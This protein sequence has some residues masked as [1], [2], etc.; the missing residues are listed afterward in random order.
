MNC[1]HSASCRQ[2]RFVSLSAPTPRHSFADAAVREHEVGKT[3]GRGNKFFP[4]LRAHRNRQFPSAAA[5]KILDADIQRRVG[6]RDQGL[7][8]SL[9]KGFHQRD[10]KLLHPKNAA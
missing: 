9:H 1:R 7:R 2:L 10:A 4:D 3:F 5:G 8:R 6:G